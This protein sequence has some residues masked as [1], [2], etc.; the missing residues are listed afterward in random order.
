MVKKSHVDRLVDS[1]C[2]NHHGTSDVR[3]ILVLLNAPEVQR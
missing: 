2:P 3:S 1:S